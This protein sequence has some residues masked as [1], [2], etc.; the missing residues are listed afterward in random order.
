MK[1]KPI[2]YL[3]LDI[4]TDGPVPGLYS[5]M[6]FGIAGIN[7]SGVCEEVFTRN[8]L[9]LTGASKSPETSKFWKSNPEAYAATQI[10]RVLPIDAMLDLHSWMKK[11]NEKY[12]LIFVAYPAVFD[13]MFL[14]YYNERFTPNNILIGFSNCIDMKSYASCKLDRPFHKT[15]KSSFPNSWFDSNLEHTHI[16]LD[17]AREQGSLWHEMRCAKY[18]NML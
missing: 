6:S 8:L 13:Y 2:L 10:D 4:E 15:T 7:N 1:A 3:S 5:M 17:D 16:A 9:P 14:V 18:P 12:K 11:L